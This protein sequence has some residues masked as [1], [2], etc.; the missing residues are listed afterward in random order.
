M[1]KSKEHILLT[2]T[3]VL[4]IAIG[5]IALLG[6][7]II[8]VAGQA[9]GIMGASVA[10][11]VIAAVYLAAGVYL[12][13]IKKVKGNAMLLTL[14]GAALLAYQ[15]Y[16]LIKGPSFSGYIGLVIPALI[17]LSVALFGKR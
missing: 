7:A 3:G 6:V 15:V 10:I 2:V 13:K 8:I 4:S 11:A 5:A 1:A 16:V 17:L 12:I 14:L 9:G